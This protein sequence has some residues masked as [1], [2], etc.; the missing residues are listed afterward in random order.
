MIIRNA[1]LAEMVGLDGQKESSEIYSDQSNTAF[2]RRYP[3]LAPT[4]TSSSDTLGW[5]ELFDATNLAGSVSATEDV[6]PPQHETPAGRFSASMP[7]ISFDLPHA[8]APWHT[9]E[10]HWQSST[11]TQ[12]TTGGTNNQS[13]DESSTI[14]TGENLLGFSADPFAPTR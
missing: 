11:I 13:M 4:P 5:N 1:G 2:F 3:F 14:V 8:Y 10:F 7:D 9:D 12:D 6:S